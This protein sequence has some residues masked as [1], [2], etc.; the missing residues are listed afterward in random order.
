MG[1]GEG[2][3]GGPVG[4]DG[5]L[6]GEGYNA[7][8]GRERSGEGAERGAEESGVEIGEAGVPAGQE[9]ADGLGDLEEGEEIGGAGSGGEE[10]RGPGGGWS[11][12]FEPEQS[13]DVGGGGG[14]E[15]EGPGVVVGAGSGDGQA[16]GGERIARS[17]GESVGEKSA[18]PGENT[19]QEGGAVRREAGGD[20]GKPVAESSKG[21]AEQGAGGAR[22]GES[23]PVGGQAVEA[24]VG[25]EEAGEGEGGHTAPGGKGAGEDEAHQE[26]EIGDGEAE[27]GGDGG[28]VGDIER[29]CEGEADGGDVDGASR[30]GYGDGVEAGGPGE[31][32]AGGP[33]HVGGE[34]TDRK[35][36]AGDGGDGGDGLNADMGMLTGHEVE[37]A[38]TGLGEIEGE[39]FG[40]PVE[41]DGGLGEGGSQTDAEFLR[42]GGDATGLVVPGGDFDFEAGG[43]REFQD[44]RVASRSCA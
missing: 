17:F 9:G 20:G 42:I 6:R 44:P 39:E 24:G 4:A 26:F 11:S 41:I 3:S 32:G 5:D 21:I 8:A 33:G 34:I 22:V 38:G 2:G 31:R 15:R 19:G 16:E 13:V 36:Q 29:G 1:T 28:W 40:E 35:G 43:R 7:V 30:V 25:A 12:G 14:G 37:D 10:G 23:G 18:Q 27:V